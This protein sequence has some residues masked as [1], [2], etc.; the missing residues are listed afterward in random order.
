MRDLEHGWVIIPAYWNC[1]I[2]WN[3]F[4]LFDTGI[5][6]GDHATISW[7]ILFILSNTLFVCTQIFFKTKTEKRENKTKKNNENE[8]NNDNNNSI[9]T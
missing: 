3:S 4:L 6:T 9:K 8:N 7:S 2:A 5:N 1:V